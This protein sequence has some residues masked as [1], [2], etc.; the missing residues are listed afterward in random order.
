MLDKTVVKVILD[1]FSFCKKA[2]ND[3]MIE[4]FYEKYPNVEQYI[5]VEFENCKE[6]EK[7][8]NIIRAL[9]LGKSLKQCKECR[10]ILPYSKSRHDFCSLTCAKKNTD[11]REKTKNTNLAR[12]GSVSPM[13]NEVIKEKTKNTFMERYGVESAFNMKDIKEKTEKTILDKYGSI[14][15]FQKAK[16]E[17]SRKTK[18]IKYAKNTNEFKDLRKRIEKTNLK[19]YGVKCNLCMP[20]IIEKNKLIHTGN[21]DIVN[22]IKETNL[23]RYGIETPFY[24][25]EV[26]KKATLAKNNKVFSKILKMK[27]YVIPMFSRA[28]FSGLNREY[29]WKCTKCGNIFTQKIHTSHHIKGF[30]NCPRCLNCYPILA[31]T[32]LLEKEVVN[33]CK[34]Y[35]PNLIEHNRTLIKPYELDIVIPELKL[36]IEFNGNFW[37]SE[38]GGTN[39]SYHLMKTEMC[40]EIGYKLIHIF[41][42]EWINKQELIKEKLKAILGVEQEKVYARKCI[43]KEVSV[44]EKNEFL[45]KYHIQGED[46]S[47]LKFGLF[48]NDELVAVMTFGYPRFNN[49]YDWELIR[50]AT[51][52]HVIG[53]A[54]KLLAYFRRTYVGSIITYADRRFSK[55]NMYEK[56]GF[57]LINITKPNYWWIKDNKV[58]SRYQTQKSRLTKL[59]SDKYDPTKTE[60]EN[61]NNAGFN[62]IYDCGNLVFTMDR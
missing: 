14:E 51:S 7:E 16:I 26:N 21:Q 27:E 29:T 1:Y 11:V 48:Y 50:Y 9:K 37:H 6:W 25:D 55:G 18:Q 20:E 28:E 2:P 12:Y 62:K 39:S 44:K 61:M 13:Q 24:N 60:M 33:F 23:K 36:A 43:V 52:K 46:K 35:Y 53:G 56:L 4:K 54:G 31:G 59:L 19:K 15:E 32:S 40:E 17:K 5:K 22:K 45:N 58:L 8:N 42:H 10:K 34:Q 3:A 47:V 30:S 41:E 49:E 57:K 38:Q